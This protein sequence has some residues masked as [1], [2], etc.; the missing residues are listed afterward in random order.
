MQKFVHA[1]NCYIFIT[2]PFSLHMPLIA[3]FLPHFLPLIATFSSHFLPLI[4]IFLSPLPFSFYMPLIATF[5]SQVLWVGEVLD[6]NLFRVI[7]GAKYVIQALELHGCKFPGSLVLHLDND[8][9]KHTMFTNK[10]YIL[11]CH[12]NKVLQVNVFTV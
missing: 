6:Q 7:V 9:W 10:S 5:L 3:T 2:F 8:K 12:I 1:T 4:A 11:A